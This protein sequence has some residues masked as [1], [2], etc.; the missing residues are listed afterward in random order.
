MVN[1][2]LEF[3]RGL[4]CLPENRCLDSIK[5]ILCRSVLCG[6]TFYLTD[7]IFS[8]YFGSKFSIV[9]SRSYDLLNRLLDIGDKTTHP[10]RKVTRIVLLLVFGLSSF[11]HRTLYYNCYAPNRERER[12]AD[13]QTEEGSEEEGKETGKKRGTGDTTETGKK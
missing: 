5:A 3:G 9:Y 6:I 8:V 7:F 12:E 4:L 11:T 1:Q 2:C 13:R 10:R